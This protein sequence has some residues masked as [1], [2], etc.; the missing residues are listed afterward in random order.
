MY[1][2]DE[3]QHAHKMKEYSVVFCTLDVESDVL[4]RKE[5]Y[6][7]FCLFLSSLSIALNAFA[8]YVLILKH[9]YKETQALS[10]VYCIF[11]L[12]N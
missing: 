8:Q 6:E 2:L 9:K 3:K 7:H 4:E 1:E 5:N 12:T 11:S 10:L